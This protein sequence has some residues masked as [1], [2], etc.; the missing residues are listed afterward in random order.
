[1]KRRCACK[2]AA[3]LPPPLQRGRQFVSKYITTI[4]VDFGVKP[5]IIDGREV[6]VNFWDLAGHP[7]FHDIRNEFYKDAQGAVLV[8]DVSS[9]KSFEGLEGWLKEA[10]K[11]GAKDTTIFVAANKV[12]KEK[13]QV[14]EKEGRQ[15]AAA[16]NFDFFETS[17]KDGD[18]VQLLFSTL[19]SRVNANFKGA[20]G[21]L[22]KTEIC[23]HSTRCTSSWQM[24]STDLWCAVLSLLMPLLSPFC[25]PSTAISRVCSSQVC[26]LF[27]AR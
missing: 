17:A 16:H 23:I 6:K 12:D 1:M 4:G 27:V 24:M 14:S 2:P 10:S 5:V 8:Y 21:L 13:R 25:C 20:H 9:R 18:N 22:C 19:F 11:Y 15:W 26:Q 7:E 3:A